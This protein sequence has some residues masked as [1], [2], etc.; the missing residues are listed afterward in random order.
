MNKRER[1][2]SETAGDKPA[3]II[4]GIIAIFWITWVLFYG[5]DLSVR[6]N[7]L[8]NQRYIYKI[9]S[10]LSTGSLYRFLWMDDHVL[11]LVYQVSGL[12]FLLLG[13]KIIPPGLDLPAY[14]QYVQQVS[15]RCLLT[16]LP[17]LLILLASLY[18]ITR[19]LFGKTAGLLSLVFFFSLADVLFLS[20][21]YTQILPASALAAGAF[22]FLLSSQNF[23]KTF[24]SLMFG[25]L[26]GLSLLADWLPGCL[27]LGIGAVYFI[28][29]NFR[30]LTRVFWRAVFLAAC[31]VFGFFL[32][33]M[34]RNPLFT[35]QEQK[36]AWT[37]FWFTLISGLI[38]YYLAR[39]FF[40][41]LEKIGAAD[42]EHRQP[43]LNFFFAL[44]LTYGL[45]AWQYLNP[46]VSVFGNNYL[47]FAPISWISEM[48]KLLL[49]GFAPLQ[50]VFL[51]LGLGWAV[52]QCRE[53]PELK[54]YLGTLGLGIL[55]FMTLG[56]KSPLLFL[57]LLLLLT[58]P[59][60]GWIE[61]IRRPWRILPALLVFLMG[62]VNLCNPTVY[63]PNPAIRVPFWESALLYPPKHRVA[64]ELDRYRQAGGADFTRPP[65]GA[66]GNWN[67]GLR[68]IAVNDALGATT[69]DMLPVK[70][71]SLE[72]SGAGSRR[73]AWVTL[74]RVFPDQP[75]ATLKALLPP[76]SKKPVKVLFLLPDHQHTT[77][78]LDY[79][80]LTYYAPRERPPLKNFDYLIYLHYQDAP[81]DRIGRDL[82]FHLGLD[83]SL[84][85]QE[86]GAL[87]LAGLGQELRLYRIAPEKERH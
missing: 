74:K 33:W 85:M 36:L 87:N 57:P 75:P 86:T 47:R 53:K 42:P 46:M 79:P 13:W 77:L 9:I 18:G 20:N 25:L 69:K 30:Y 8:E 76:P 37:I 80:G 14:Q 40:F 68:Q 60:V 71:F 34:I 32:E 1:G 50:L 82:T 39:K 48:G 52:F 15:L 67:P 3:F 26:L 11:P 65:F 56:R 24:D 5:Y 17:F 54:I 51:V 81:A 29:L 23:Q 70:L 28:H 72:I 31:G 49:Y 35:L 22:Y 21:L 2:K 61:G 83:D 63:L 6:F 43:W 12:S 58:P 19:R 84:R 7:N 27:L 62:L 41:Q 55:I 16:Q 78:Y 59:A 44:L 10:A 45:T 73:L 4:L 38:F 66:P 64:G